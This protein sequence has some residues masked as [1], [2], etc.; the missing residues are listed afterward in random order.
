MIS[1]S[2]SAA[3]NDVGLID[4]KLILLFFI[5]LPLKYLKGILKYKNNYF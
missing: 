4:F 3:I 5:L 1:D 2:Q